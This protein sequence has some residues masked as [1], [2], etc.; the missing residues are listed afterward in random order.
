MKHTIS[1][2]LILQIKKVYEINFAF[3]PKYEQLLGR[4]FALIRIYTVECIFNNLL[5][6]LRLYFKP[7]MHNII[8]AIICTSVS[9]IKER[10]I[11][12]KT[13]KVVMGGAIHQLAS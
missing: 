12:L 5:K 1:V 4:M 10:K 11:V 6:F 7:S 2:E 3:F 9:I 13:L 8:V